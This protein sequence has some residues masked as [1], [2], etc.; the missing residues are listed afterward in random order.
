MMNI[1]S[2]SPDQFHDTWAPKVEAPRP[3]TD[4]DIMAATKNTA[5]TIKNSPVTPAVARAAKRLVTSRSRGKIARIEIDGTFVRYLDGVTWMNAG[6][7]PA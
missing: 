1:N 6:H 3:V 4:A 5:I 2:L 7:L